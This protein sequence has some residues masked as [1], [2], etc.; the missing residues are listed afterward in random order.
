MG[1]VQPVIRKMSATQ[2]YVT[3]TSFLLCC[4]TGTWTCD[5][6]RIRPPSARRNHWSVMKK[7][8]CERKRRHR[9]G[10]MGAV[11]VRSAA[12][13]EGCWG[14][15]PDVGRVMV[16]VLV[17]SLSLMDEVAEGTIVLPR[18]EPGGGK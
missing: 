4:A 9:A 11:E 14:D 15:G 5:A 12:L 2:R 7:L 6:S 10:W 13:R 17:A 1:S 16:V 18:I 3:T 8:M